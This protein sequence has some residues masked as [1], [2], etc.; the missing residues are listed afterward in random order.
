MAE[1]TRHELAR[2]GHPIRP[3]R[4]LTLGRFVDS[5]SEKASAP[6]ALLH[7]RIKE[8]LARLALPRFRAVAEFPGLHHAIATLMEEAPRSAVPEDLARIFREVERELEKRGCALRSTRLQSVC[9]NPGLLAPHI[10]FDGFFS[11]AASELELLVSLSRRTSLTVTLPSAAPRLLEAGFEELPCGSPRRNAPASVVACPTLDRET[12]EIARRILEEVEGG[13]EFREIGIVLRVREPYGSALETTLRRFGIPARFY[14]A[15]PLAEHPAIDYLSRIIESMLNGWDHATLLSAIRMPVSGIG[16]TDGGDKLDFA[17][18]EKLPGFGLAWSDV[19]AA[20]AVLDQLALLSWRDRVEPETW[21]QRLAKLRGLFPARVVPAGMDR[22]LQSTNAALDAFEQAVEQCAAMVEGRFTLEE[23]WP[24]VRTALSL[25]TLRLPDR[26]RNV[27]HVMDVFEARQWELPVVFVCGMVER[28]FPQYHR[29]NPLLNDAARRR[30]GLRTSA[31]LQNEERFL[32]QIAT[33]RATAKTILTFAR[34]NEKGEESIPSFFLEDIATDASGSRIRPRPARGA[35]FSRKPAIREDASLARLGEMHR[36]LGATSIESFLQCPFLFYAG[37]TLRLVPRPPAPRDRL[38]MRVQGSVLHRALAELA[39]APLLGSAV[40]DEVFDQECRRANIP[41]GYRREA[42]RFELLRNFETFLEDRQVS[43]GWATR[44]EE[45]FSFALTPLITITGRIDRLDV[46]P[47]N[48]ALVIDYKYSA[49]S[50]IRDLVSDNEDGNLV[51]GGLYLAA[52]RRVFGL[53]P[54]G[55]LYCGLRKEVKWGGWHASIPTLEQIGERR[56]PEAMQELIATAEAKAVET[57]EA[58]ASGR[59]APQ[60]A[61][62]KKCAWCDFRDVCRVE[63]APR[64]RTAGE[65]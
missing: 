14:F 2:A 35:L 60:P 65:A 30:A 17:M 38:D 23:F 13:R 28:H 7:L 42:V 3:S 45:K 22:R 61:D 43:L 40:L 47:R 34:F 33:S 44:A 4:I 51:Q 31:D 24:V 62:T 54:A 57:Y 25:E 20:Q 1:H 16:A 52:A 26:R 49:A 48:Q 5:H 37:K 53:E 12:E 18:R 29:E 6:P 55:M 59:I 50:K 8:A 39:R 9:E 10:V 46:G 58:V 64:T 32:F 63:S 56:T 36:K 11:L 15:D 27:V 41:E 19:P 21:K